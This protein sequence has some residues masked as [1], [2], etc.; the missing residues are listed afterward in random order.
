MTIVSD[1]RRAGFLER[2]E[3]MQ[4][5]CN[6]AGSIS[7]RLATLAVLGE[8]LKKTLDVQLAQLVSESRQ[9]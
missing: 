7:S 2:V 1:T 4:Y 6:V 3:S 8:N 9:P 5:L